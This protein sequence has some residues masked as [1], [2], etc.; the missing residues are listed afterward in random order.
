MSTAC[1]C[2]QHWTHLDAQGG[3][4]GQVLQGIVGRQRRPVG[5]QVRAAGGQ[6]KQ[7]LELAEACAIS[8][9]HTLLAE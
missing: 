1:G 4:A 8:S 6:D 2:D 5:W 3:E 9:M 7:V